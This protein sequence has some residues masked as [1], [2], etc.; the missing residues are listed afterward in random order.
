MAFHGN[1]SVHH[2]YEVFRDRIVTGRGL[3]ISHEQVR[4]TLNES[5]SALQTNVFSMNQTCRPSGPGRNH[6]QYHLWNSTARSHL[7]MCKGCYIM[8]WLVRG[9]FGQKYQRVQSEPP[10]PDGSLQD[11]N[12]APMR[13]GQEPCETDGRCESPHPAGAVFTKRVSSL[14]WMKERDERPPFTPKKSKR[15]ID[16]Y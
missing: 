10:T 16:P 2:G 1:K 13:P 11:L 14:N 15:R 5:L 3:K 8:G 7:I 12:R 9:I 6:H 4:H